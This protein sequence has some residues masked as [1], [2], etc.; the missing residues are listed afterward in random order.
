MR[1]LNFREKGG[2]SLSKVLF[3]PREKEASQ[4]KDI[5]VILYIAVEGNHDFLGDD[6]LD[7]IAMQIARAVGPSGPNVEYLFNLANSL[8]ENGIISEDDRKH[9]IELRDRVRALLENNQNS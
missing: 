2:Y 7:A 9:T 1:I 8:E 3:T 6:S 5:Q 4:E